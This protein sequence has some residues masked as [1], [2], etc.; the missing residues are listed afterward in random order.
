MK[1]TSIRTLSSV[2]ILFLFLST[3]LVAQ[4][5]GEWPQWRG[6]N[7]DG[8]SKETGL[9]KQWPAD[10]PALVWKA[11]GAGRG[12]STMSIANG[13]LFTM[14]LRGDRE[15]VIGTPD[16]FCYDRETNSL[17]GWT[18]E[19][20]RY[21]SL[22]PNDAGRLWSTQLGLW[23]GPWQGE[24]QGLDRLWLRFFHEDGTVVLTAEEFALSEA[25]TA[26][27]ENARLKA[28]LAEMKVTNE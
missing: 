21:Q 5:P 12:Y 18:I 7:R 10:G 11:T 4:T 19:H 27:K 13:R 15:Y 25:A 2:A 24:F 1:N 26:R 8:I 20:S 3:N 16:Y 14:G 28:I 6:P 9:L 17:L 22:T 23:L